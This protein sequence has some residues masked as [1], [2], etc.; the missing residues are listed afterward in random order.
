MCIDFVN[1]ENAKELKERQK[2]LLYIYIY[3]LGYLIN[4]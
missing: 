2:R 1:I 4:Y 3:M